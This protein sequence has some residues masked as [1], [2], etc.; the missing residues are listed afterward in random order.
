MPSALPR[1]THPHLAPA[2]LAALLAC[3]SATAQT[4]YTYKELVKPSGSMGCA[5]G[6]GDVISTHAMNSQGDVAAFCYT[7]G[8]YK[9]GQSTD[10]GYNPFA[11]SPWYLYRPVLWRAGASAKA[12]PLT[13]RHVAFGIAPLDTGHVVARTVAYDGKVLSQAP[14]DYTETRWSPTLQRSPW[15][16]C[17]EGA[18]L[19]RVVSRQGRFACLTQGGS[20]IAVSNQGTDLR[21]LPPMPG[22]QSLLIDMSAQLA[23]ND[24]GQVAAVRQVASNQGPRSEAWLWTGTA[25]QAM[26]L[27]EGLS[28]D[29]VV[30]L[31][32]QGAALLRAGGGRWL[33]WQDGQARQLEL[34]NMTPV[35]LD[36]QGRVLGSEPA[37]L[38][39][40]VYAAARVWANGQLSAPQ[41]LVSN[42]PAKWS[43]RRVVDSLPDGRLLVEVGDFSQKYPSDSKLVLLTPQ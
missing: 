34:G 5:V 13:T 27:P 8:G 42:W 9:F 41:A 21:T 25:W 18:G 1:V 28:P 10:Y 29:F 12:L 40:G 3:G 31:N 35:A 2:A 32:N 4:A 38:N 24:A 43:A 15:Q 7:V 16:P 26:A 30:S 33:L 36:D 11:I 17:G 20:A 23:V 39:N 22:A 19:L 6:L 14:A 37:S